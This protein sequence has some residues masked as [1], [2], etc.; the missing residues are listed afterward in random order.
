MLLAHSRTLS[1]AVHFAHSVVSTTEGAAGSS[2]SCV[3]AAYGEVRRSELRR[4][5]KTAGAPKRICC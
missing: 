2:V 4:R 3:E 5:E 1:V